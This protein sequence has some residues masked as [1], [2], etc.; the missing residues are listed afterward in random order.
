[1]GDISQD[2]N[3]TIAPTEQRTDARIR[4]L[5]DTAGVTLQDLEVGRSTIAVTTLDGSILSQIQ[6]AEA[7]EPGQ[8]FM[9]AGG[10][11]HLPRPPLPDR[12]AQV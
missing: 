3:P 10:S 5:L 9:A 11:S 7:T 12:F 4:A 6:A 8:F 1:L 2:R